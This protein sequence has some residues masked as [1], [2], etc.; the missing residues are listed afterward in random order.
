MAAYQAFFGLAP[1][2]S[3]LRNPE[4]QT[5]E[6]ASQPVLHRLFLNIT[7]DIGMVPNGDVFT[8]G[9][10]RSWLNDVPVDLVSIFRVSDTVWRVGIV[11]DAE[12]GDEF[13]VQCAYPDP[14]LLTDTGEK[15]LGF[16]TICDTYSAAKSKI[17][18]GDGKIIE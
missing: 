1:V 4:P 14:L 18:D 17:Y 12:D 6:V 10:W 5:W 9:S 2:S 16:S 11:R 8:P 15:L 13:C 7:F 3:Q